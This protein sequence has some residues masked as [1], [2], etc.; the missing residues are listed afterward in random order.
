MGKTFD[1]RSYLARHDKR[2]LLS[3]L[4]RQALTKL[5][6]LLFALVYF[7]KHLAAVETGGEISFSQF[8]LDLA[9]AAKQWARKDLGPAELREAWVAPRGSGKS[10]WMFLILPA[11]ALAH[12]HRKYIAAFADNAGIAE[13]HLASL[14]RELT[15]NALLRRDY[16]TL[17]RA[18][19]RPSG[20]AEGDN[21][22]LYL[23]ESGAAF[24]A[25]GIDSNTLGAKIGNQRPDL[26]LFDDVEPDESNYSMYQKDKR[27]ATILQAVFPMNVNAVVEFVGTVQM[28]GSI[29]HDV[30]QQATDPESAPAWVA[31]EKVKTRYYPAIVMKDDGTEV[32]LWPERWGID[33]L[34]SERHKKS[35]AL[36]YMN[37]PVSAEGAY[38][39]STDFIYEPVAGITKRIIS[40]DPA[41]TTKTSSDYTG[42]AVISYSPS[43]QRCVVEHASQVKLSPLEL[44]VYLL[45]LIEKTNARMVLIETTQGGDTWKTI[46]NELPVPIHEVKPSVKKEV[47]WAQALDYWQNQWVSHDGPV[48]AFEDQAVAVPRAANDDVVDAVTAGVSYFL[49]GKKRGPTQARDK[50]Y[51]YA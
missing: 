44:K 15:N 5:D 46:L 36:N 2:L 26:L 48:K 34:Q 38:W 6:P 12:G 25:R 45:S 37:K 3:P 4:G 43:E 47:R 40:V 32:S 18:S 29:M 13:K 14:K 22:T 11:W 31:D 27:L 50:Q 23:A 9:E 42:V 33:W 20:T 41:V 21:R 24:Q 39:S 17:V 35:F 49:R 19:R 51:A 30:V 10:T 1:W 7:R 28:H 8:H 16:P